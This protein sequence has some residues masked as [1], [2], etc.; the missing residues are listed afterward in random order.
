MKRS[1]S[2]GL[3]SAVVLC[4]GAAG[5]TQTQPTTYHIYAGNTHAHTIFT[6]SHGDH[7]EKPPPG[8]KAGVKVDDKGSQH[9]TTAQILR[10]DWQ[11]HQGPP[12]EHFARAKANGY[13]FYITTDHSQESDFQPPAS[14]NQKWA[15]TKHAAAQATD[16]TFV[17]IA[18]YEHSENDGPAG[19]GHLNV[20][21]SD[22]YLNAMAAGVDLPKLYQWLKTAKPNGEGPIV[23]TFNH[24]GVH[25][26]NDWAYRDAEVTDIITLL[27]MINSNDRIHYDAF[28]AALDKGWKVSPVCG[29]DNHG[30]WGITNQK[31]RTFVLATEKTK[32]AIL[33]G[34][35]QRRTYASLDTNLQCRYTVNGSIMGS[36]LA[37]GG[38]IRV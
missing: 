29:N 20:I 9:P 8:V 17:A 31:S 27:E 25:A 36:T 1:L 10:P 38:R 22:A 2:F 5:Q 37:A 3:L 32:A 16:A 35:K 13:D 26:Y 6:W 7:W 33:D 11:K 23:V 18:G 4:L 12:A 30:F 34:M 14:D 24:P 19:T 28:L 21:N 15:D